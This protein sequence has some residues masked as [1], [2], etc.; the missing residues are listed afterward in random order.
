MSSSLLNSQLHH[1]S[2]S[3]ASGSYISSDL[4]VIQSVGQM[5][6]IGNFK[7]DKLKFFQG[8]QQPILKKVIKA[9]DLGSSFIAF[10]NPFSSDINFHYID[11][12]NE[13]VNI[14]V[15]DINGKLLKELYEQTESNKLH[16]DLSEIKKGT[17][18][19][20]ISNSSFDV[21]TKVLK[22]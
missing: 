2:I 12:K 5:G 13:F 19:I 1:Q 3:S 4:V 22:K 6:P 20:N 11:F 10:P 7:S 15:Y 17:Y 8:F 9:N 21:S 16:L 14:S 18:L